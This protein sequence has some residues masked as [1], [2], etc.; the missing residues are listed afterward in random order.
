MTNTLATLRLFKALPV[1]TKKVLGYRANLYEINLKTIPMGFVLAPEVTEAYPN[2]DTVV[3]EVDSLYG[4]N[5]ED[6]NKTLHKSFNKVATASFYRLLAEQVVHYYT[7]YGAEALGVYDPDNVYMPSERL[8]VPPIDSKEFPL[9]VIRGLT[10]D[11]LR[12]ALLNLLVSGVALSEQSVEDALS[13]ASSVSLTDDEI[14]EI[15]NRE[16]KIGLYELYGKVPADP[17]EFLRLV[18]YKTTGSTL[19]IKSKG[20]VTAVAEGATA[21]NVLPLFNRYAQAHGLETLSKIFLRYKPLFLA[22]RSDASMR[23]VVNRIRRLAVQNHQPMKQDYLNSV[24]A[25]IKNGG[26]SGGGLRYGLLRH[27][28]SDSNV[29]IYRKIRLA[30][31]LAVRLDPNLDAALYR[32][33]NGKSFA[34]T[35]TPFNRQESLE[36]MQAYATVMESIA[37]S[38]APVVDGKRIYIPAGVN[39]GLPSTEKQ[40]TGTLPAGTYVE[41]DAANGLGMGMVAGIYWEDQSGHRVDLDLSV[42]NLDGK[43]G[44]DGNYRSTDREVLFSGDVTSAPKG[45]SE[46][47]YFGDRAVGSWMLNVNYFN[48]RETVPVPFKIVVGSSG[49]SD[50]RN[51]YMIDSNRLLASAADVLDVHQKNL[52][53][54]VC[55]S[56]PDVPH[57]F[58]FA[59]S[60]MGGGITTRHNAHAEQARRFMMSAL[61]TSPTLNDVLEKAGAILVTDRALVDDQTLDLSPS[62]VDKT[63]VLSLLSAGF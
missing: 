41:F 30:R 6:L 11:E 22:L 25:D 44:W 16:V 23:P 29:N 28:L 18:V 38:L 59:T 37:E 60:D 53:M 50:I 8:D 58:Y 36:A 5:P 56:N 21:H 15:K 2:T 62:A 3:R 12:A 27:A 57:R 39:Y 10:P 55:D 48:F 32:V 13:V 47:F 1:G 34:T 46:V 4:V 33:R 9:T 14:E 26:L 52:G 7:T 19:L 43:F 35:M 17:A 40:F 31:A 42:S 45:A 61:K 49:Y 51:N 24:T 20:A 63:T 54:I